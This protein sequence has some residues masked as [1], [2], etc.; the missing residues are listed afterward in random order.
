MASVTEHFK[1]NLTQLSMVMLLNSIFSFDVPQVTSRLHVKEGS[2]WG[3]QEDLQRRHRGQPGSQRLSWQGGIWLSSQHQVQIHFLTYDQLPHLRVYVR[4]NIFNAQNRQAQSLGSSH[5]Y[6]SIL[7]VSFSWQI[8]TIWKDW[9]GELL[10]LSQGHLWGLTF[11][12]G[13][14]IWPWAWQYVVNWQ[15]Y[16]NWNVFIFKKVP[17]QL[18]ILQ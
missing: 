15:K 1:L 12:I 13:Y 8:F 14:R 7:Y 9:Q 6:L 18:K 5:P 17:Q 16:F 2:W 11:D 3:D 10:H 4:I